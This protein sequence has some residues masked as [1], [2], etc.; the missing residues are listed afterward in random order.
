MAEI[1]QH[2][3]DKRNELV[4]ALSKQDYKDAQ[5]ARIFNV[6][7]AVIGRIIKRMPKHWKPKWQK[8]QE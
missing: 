4:W 8:V 7:R 2:L 6:D 3:L 5:I 1:E